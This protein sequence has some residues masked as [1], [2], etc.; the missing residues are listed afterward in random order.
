MV[1]LAEPHNSSARWQHYTPD[2]KS[3]PHG[4]RED[5]GNKCALGPSLPIV[6]TPISTLFS[7]PSA[8]MEPMHVEAVRNDAAPSRTGL[9]QDYVRIECPQCWAAY[10]LYHDGMEAKLLRRHFLRP[11]WQIS[12][13]H[14]NHNPVIVF[15]NSSAVTQEQTS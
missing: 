12:R 2:L 6:V 1:G 4:R 9:V 11:S 7:E 8:R 5:K 15:E 13:A 10:Y 14:P 3:R